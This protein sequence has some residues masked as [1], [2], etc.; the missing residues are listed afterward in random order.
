[1]GRDGPRAEGWVAWGGGS[2]VQDSVCLCWEWTRACPLHCEARNPP[3]LLS[4]SRVSVPSVL[5]LTNCLS[6][7]VLPSLLTSL[8][9]LHVMD[10]SSG[11]PPLLSV[12]PV[13]TD[14]K[15]RPL[16]PSQA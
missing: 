10:G 8:N 2:Q 9:R 6:P 12:D 1:M 13:E 4:A 14:E 15:A 16:T 11:S 3:S 5:E 7:A